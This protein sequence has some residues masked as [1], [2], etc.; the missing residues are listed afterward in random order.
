MNLQPVDEGYE[1]RMLSS[2]I[3][4]ND[5]EGA[6]AACHNVGEYFWHVKDDFERAFKLFE[7]NCTKKGYGDSCFYVGKL[8]CKITIIFQDG[9]FV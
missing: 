7:P 3:D 1:N 2:E 6:P 4:C 8:Y 5:G 9:F